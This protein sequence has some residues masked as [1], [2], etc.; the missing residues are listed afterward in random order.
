MP[1]QSTPSN[2]A[3]ASS[4]L[5]MPAI[6]V[7]PAILAPIVI[8]VMTL[9]YF[10]ALVNPAAHLHGL[11]VS[12]VDEDRGMS[13]GP[14]RLNVGQQVEQALT[15][16]PA[17]TTRL[18]LR[19]ATLASA[20]TSMNNGTDYATVV[21]PPGFTASLVAVSGI[22]TSTGRSATKPTV[23]LLTNPRAGTLGVTL[24]AG[25]IQ[26]AIGVV[27][28]QIGQRLMLLAPADANAATH[29]FLTDPVTLASVTYHP[30]PA[31]S[32]LGLS[33]FYVSL[34]TIMCGFLG[35]IFVNSSVD[36]ALGYVSSEVGPWWRQRRMV[37]ITRWQTL[38]TKWA[39]A[40]VLM[41]VLSGMLL[42][43]SA[44]ILR[45][46][47][48]HLWLLWLYTW[49]AATVVAIGTLTLFAA[50]GLLGQ[51]VAIL[52][53]VYVALASSGGTVPLQALPGF[54][55]FLASFEPL[56]QIL[57][58]VRSILYLDAQAGAGLTRAVVTTT[59]GLVFWVIVGVIITIWYDRRGLH[60]VQPE[61]LE[62]VNRAIASYGEQRQH[63]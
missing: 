4:L 26:P 12:I 40:T 23:E 38:L 11:P 41:V 33:A 52:V 53:F 50:L 55:R 6:W 54:Y 48:P 2:Q 36:A 24:A 62:Y 42:A 8:L 21:I 44:G 28:H 27:S 49:F 18:A 22:S 9:V 63:T 35:G 60:R 51:I 30:L 59:L 5:R 37:P 3:R 58:G 56:R 45:M 29:A 16:A 15:T 13:V 7:L 31:H 34:L 10:G 17:V 39:I 61:V 47:A 14:Q 46:D 19:P 43:A 25:V 57:D 32:A 1:E 20:R